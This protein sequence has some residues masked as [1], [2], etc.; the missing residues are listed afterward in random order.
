MKAS[1]DLKIA[2]LMHKT[3]NA[4]FNKKP[5]PLGWDYDLD[6]NPF[7]EDGK[8]YAH[9]YAKP[10]QKFVRSDPGSPAMSHVRAPS[11]N[12]PCDSKNYHNT[13]VEL[14]GMQR[15]NQPKVLRKHSE[16]KTKHELREALKHGQQTHSY[17]AGL[18]IQGPIESHGR[19]NSYQATLQ[20]ANYTCGLFGPKH[21]N[22]RGGRMI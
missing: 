11:M 15:L 4:G 12:E 5:L 18:R 2:N 22:S 9:Q 14:P 1:R 6:Q 17:W 19:T 16:Y 7:E 20:T 8:P 10:V 3:M 13:T 21:F